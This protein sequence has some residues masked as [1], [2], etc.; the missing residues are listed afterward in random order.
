MALG[1]VYGVR[2]T[3][4]DRLLCVRTGLLACAL[5]AAASAVVVTTDEVGSTAA[6]RL[7]RLSVFAPALS[8]VACIV[9]ERQ[10]VLRGEL[11]TLAAL[12]VTAPRALRGALL[13]AWL[14][15]AVAL[16]LVASPWSDPSSLFPSVA[17]TADWLLVDGRLVEPGAGLSVGAEGDIER[18]EPAAAAVGVDARRG[19]Q[20]VVGA[21]A[22]VGPWWA[23][24]SSGVGSRWLAPLATLLGTIVLLHAAAAGRISVVLLPA[25]ALP[26]ALHALARWRRQLGVEA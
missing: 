16:G 17:G 11:A 1:Q 13:A 4:F 23:I 6:E 2:L 22:L 14:V 19:A 8:V 20:L 15:G 5:V 12:G 21:L 18:F 10:A 24:A 25:A 3:P 9:V 26:L 7:A